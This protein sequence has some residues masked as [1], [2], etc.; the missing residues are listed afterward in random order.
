MTIDSKDYARVFRV[1]ARSLYFSNAK[2][3]VFL[4]DTTAAQLHAVSDFIDMGAG[5]SQAARHVKLKHMAKLNEAIFF[6][7]FDFANIAF[8]EGYTLEDMLTLAFTEAEQDSCFSD[9]SASEGQAVGK[10]CAL[11][12]WTRMQVAVLRSYQPRDDAA[13]SSSDGRQAAGIPRRAEEGPGGNLG[14]VRVCVS[15]H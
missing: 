7:D 6:D 1:Q 15:S 8:L 2:V 5:N 12:L 13:K 10:R 11:R 9:P 14:R 4:G 3:D